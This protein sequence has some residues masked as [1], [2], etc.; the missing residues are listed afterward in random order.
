MKDSPVFSRSV[1]G[2]FGRLIMSINWAK[3]NGIYAL[4]SIPKHKQTNKIR[5]FIALEFFL[6][7]P[8]IRCIQKFKEFRNNLPN[9]IDISPIAHV[10]LL[11]TDMKSGF[12]F[13]PSIGIK[14]A[15]KE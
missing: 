1:F 5:I 15:G 4:V 12:K 13:C 10:A 7:N 11:H 9:F 2:V 3:I 8:F 6:V 14:S